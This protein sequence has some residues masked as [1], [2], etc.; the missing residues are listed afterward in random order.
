MFVAKK[1]C[2]FAGRDFLIGDPIPE[3]LVL[4]SRVP[5]LIKTGVLDEFTEAE[6]KTGIVKFSIPVHAEEGDVQLELTN[7]ELVQ[8]F[9]VLQSTAEEAESVVDGITS[10]DALILLDVADSRKAVKKIVRQR[11]SV[12]F[13]AE[14][15]V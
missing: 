5:D 4:K 14:E 9:D 7:E 2:S 6:E 8:V 15:E 12:L 1:P 3:E 13:P 11:A 10:N